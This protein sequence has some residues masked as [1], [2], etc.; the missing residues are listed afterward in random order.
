MSE[1]WVVGLAAATA[2]GALAARSVPFVVVA[3]VLGVAWWLRRPVVVCLAAA[4]LASALGARAWAGL[5]GC[6]TREIRDTVTLVGDPADRYG[7]V[8]VEARLQGRRVEAWAR[9]GS[10][11]R[12]GRMLAGERVEI[13][14]RL[15]PLPDAVASRLAWR[16]VACRLTVTAAG[17]AHRADP[18]HAAANA[19]RRTLV[20][21]AAALPERDRGLFGGFVLGDDRAQLPDVVDD[22]RGAGLSHLLVVSGQNVAFAMALAAPLVR[23]GRLGSRLAWGIAVLTAFGV[24]TR[25]EPS[26]LRAVAMAGLALLAGT[27]ARPAPTLRLLA[28]ATTGV[29]LVDPLL[30][31]SLGFRLSVAACCGIAT[32][33]PVVQRALPK[34]TIGA[35]LAVTIGAQAGVAPLLV[36]AFDGVP[37]ASVPANLLALPL[38]GPL[39]VWGMVAGPV[40]GITGG[41]V[42]TVLHFPTR[43]AIGWI[44]T[45]ARTAADLPLGN[46]RSGHLV[47]LVLAV[48]LGARFVRLRSSAALAALVVVCA[49][50]VSGAIERGSPP[51]RTDLVSGTVVWRD[52]TATVLVLEEGSAPALLADLRRLGV[53]H[54]DVLVLRRRAAAATAAGVIERLSPRLVLAPA[55][56]ALGGIRTPPDGATV[57][58]GRLR[59]TTRVAGAS[60]DVTVSRGGLG[61]AGARG[62]GDGDP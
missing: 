43:L 53:E 60:L 5:D 31:H 52:G 54:A 49:P 3:A 2:C 11:A 23:R 37:V 38:A 61:S 40:A 24:L 15:S 27:M 57:G 46:L 25:W 42:A 21:G 32:V 9:G 20:R 14:G 50:A 17:D 58:L 56:T 33:T 13:E 44:A 59:I 18:M 28:L 36:A 48:L 51:L 7:A 26:V 16:H 12:L 6:P 39:M 19:L 62:S 30:V 47:A 41:A 22:F 10:A 8:R 1:R 35:M 55:G 29:L 4:V 34:D 45:V